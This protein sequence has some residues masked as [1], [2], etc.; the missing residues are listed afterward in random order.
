LSSGDGDG[1]GGVVTGFP[2]S[3]NGSVG[4][5]AAAYSSN[6]GGGDEL[7]GRQDDSSGEGGSG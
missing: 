1:W 5:V 6:G 7:G 3:G 2:L 4:T